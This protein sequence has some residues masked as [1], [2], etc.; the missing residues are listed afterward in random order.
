MIGSHPMRN[1]VFNLQMKQYYNNDSTAFGLT[2]QIKH[3]KSFTSLTCHAV[4]TKKEENMLLD[5]D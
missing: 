2:I 4:R 3:D 1:D 5:T